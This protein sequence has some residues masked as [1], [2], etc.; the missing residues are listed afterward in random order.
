M[1]CDANVHDLLSDLRYPEVMFSH[2][3]D[4]RSTCSTQPP[5]HVLNYVTLTPLPRQHTG[6]DE[7]IA[8]HR[9]V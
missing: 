1:L 7:V 3:G 2:E 9:S 4:R 5:S 6:G 8:M